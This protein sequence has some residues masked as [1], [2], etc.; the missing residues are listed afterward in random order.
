MPRP[1]I[2]DPSINHQIKVKS[3]NDGSLT[4][5][6]LGHDNADHGLVRSREV[7]LPRKRRHKKTQ[8]VCGDQH[9]FYFSLNLNSNRRQCVIVQTFEFSANHSFRKIP[10]VN[11][12]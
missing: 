10:N 8:K 6:D 9:I 11:L 2:L 1:P 4:S 7:V 3:L 5:L 12:T